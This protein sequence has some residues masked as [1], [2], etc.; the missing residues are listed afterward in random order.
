MSDQPDRFEQVLTGI[1]GLGADRATVTIDLGAV[2]AHLL[3]VRTDLTGGMG[4]LQDSLTAIRDDIGVNMGRADAAV[5]AYAGTR[6][7]V[8]GFEEQFGLVCH[9]IRHLENRV[10]EN[11]GD[12]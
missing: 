10:R 6:E 12:P 8:R 5:G 9:K 4:R 1:T 2:K 7:D 3:G 11:G